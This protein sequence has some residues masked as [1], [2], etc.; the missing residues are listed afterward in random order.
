MNP[1]KS[2]SRKKN[3][4]N[5]K[6]KPAKAQKNSR[7]DG[8]GAGRSVSLSSTVLFLCLHVLLPSRERGSLDLPTSPSGIHDCRMNLQVLMNVVY[9]LPRT[10]NCPVYPCK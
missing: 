4:V 10:V 1:K 9:H 6:L 5:S 3:G 8:R 7:G 2:N